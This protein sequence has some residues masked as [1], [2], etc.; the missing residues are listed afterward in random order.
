MEQRNLDFDIDMTREQW[1]ELGRTADTRGPTRSGFAWA[2]DRFDEI[3][4]FLRD[5]DAPSLWRNFV[6][7]AESY[8]AEER[9]IAQFRFNGGRPYAELHLPESL[10]EPVVSVQEQET[11][12]EELDGWIRNKWHE[13]VRDSGLHYDRGHIPQS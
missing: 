5:A 10:E 11:M 7:D 9:E 12:R 2:P 1:L 13:L 8:G 3:H 6:S 4:V